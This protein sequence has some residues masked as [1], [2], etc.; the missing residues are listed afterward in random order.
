MGADA[1]ALE[2][3]GDMLRVVGDFFTDRADFDLPGSEPEREGSGVVLDEN[4]EEA[5]DGTEQRAVDH[6]RLVAGAIFGNVFKAEASGKIEIELDGG[7][8]P[9]TAD[10][11]D[12][13]DVDF[14]AVKSAFALNRLVRDI[15][16][17]QGV[18]QDGGG[19]APV[20]GLAL[21]IFRMRSVPIGELDLK[22]VEAKVFHYR[23]GEIDAGF[24]FFFNLR[25]SAEN[26]RVVLGEASNAEKAVQDSAT[27]VAIDGAE[28]GE[29][30]GKIAIAVELGF[31][32]E[33]V[34]GTVHRLQLVIGLFYFD[35]AEHA[36]FVEIGVA[37]GFP[38]VQTHDV[39]RVYEIVAAGEEFVA[40]PVFDDF[41]NQ[42]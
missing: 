16:P 42:A 40:Q 17:L 15:E 29:A 28:F 1:E 3:F 12:E 6:E 25:G 4:A 18:G 13:L 41:A 33:D 27:L 10:G 35:W 21:V 36:V 5:L 30:H 14:R 26:V 24:H 8:L 22:F 7:E 39:R 23:E 38:E 34:A 31:V 19:A 11:V 9:G 32:D 2:S 37:A 20:F